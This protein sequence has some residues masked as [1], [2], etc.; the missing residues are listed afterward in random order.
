M[1]KS[2][3]T[4]LALCVTPTALSAQSQIPPSAEV[5]FQAHVIPTAVLVVDLNHAVCNGRTLTFEMKALLAH[6][7]ID[8]GQSFSLASFRYADR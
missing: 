6:T 1:V 7:R 2:I 5:R 4:G 3:L 8:C